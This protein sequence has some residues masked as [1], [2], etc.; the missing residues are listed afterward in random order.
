VQAVDIDAQRRIVE[1]LGHEHVGDRRRQPEFARDILRDFIVRIEIGPGDLY[2]N[3]SR[4]THAEDCIHQT[5]GGEEGSQLR[6]LPGHALLDPANVFITADAMFGLQADLNEPGVHGRVRRVY[7]REAIVDADIIHNGAQIV[8]PGNLLDQSFEIRDFALSVTVSLVPEGALKVITNCP[9]SVR[10]KYAKPSW[11]YRSKLAAKTRKNRSNT[12][13]QR[14]PRTVSRPR[15][16]SNEQ[17][18]SR[19]TSFPARWS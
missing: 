15:L 8:R 19:R 9:A 4:R 2:V 6:H 16:T 1:I 17:G 13:V 12:T 18:R 11:L 3:R 5:S 14:R 7:R 10:G